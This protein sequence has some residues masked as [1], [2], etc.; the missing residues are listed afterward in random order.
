MEKWEYRVVHF[1]TVSGMKTG[2]S[3]SDS[4]DG[5]KRFNITGTKLGYVQLIASYLSTL[6]EEGWEVVMPMSDWNTLI[7]PP[8]A[9]AFNVVSPTVLLRRKKV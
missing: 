1:D 7:S 8:L 2:V 6:G 5:D 4:R 9:N 3:I